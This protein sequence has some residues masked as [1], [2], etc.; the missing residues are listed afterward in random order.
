MVQFDPLPATFIKI[1]G[2]HNTA[3]EVSPPDSNH[4]SDHNAQIVPKP[5]PQL[6]LSRGNN[7]YQK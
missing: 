1:V 3:N 5:L 2:T 4:H 7:L 6:Y